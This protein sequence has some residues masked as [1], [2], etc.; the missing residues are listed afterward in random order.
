MINVDTGAIV[1]VVSNG[2]P[3][4]NNRVDTN[5]GGDVLGKAVFNPFGN[6][7]IYTL[8]WRRRRERASTVRINLLF[9]EGKSKLYTTSNKI[10]A[11]S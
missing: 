4:K 7:I 8:G 3:G 10:G 6:H 1:L 5:G 11:A 2:V 9:T